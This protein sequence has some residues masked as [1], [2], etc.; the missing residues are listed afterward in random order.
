M[1]YKEKMNLV[2]SLLVNLVN[3][4]KINV[5]DRHIAIYLINNYKTVN[6]DTITILAKSLQVSIS[7]LSRFVKNIGFS[8]YGEFKDAISYHGDT[9]RHSDLQHGL[10]DIDD[11]QRLVTEEINYFYSN[12][13]SS[14]LSNL[15]D[16][17]YKTNDVALFGLLNSNNAAKELQYNLMRLNKICISYDNLMAQLNYLKNAKKDTL[18]IIFS[19]SGQYVLDNDY[20][21][22][23]KVISYLK[24]T[25][26]KTY[27]LTKNSE[28]INLDYLD[29]III[30]PTKNN[31]PN[32]TWQCICDLIFLMY[33][34]R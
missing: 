33:Q 4:P 10:V 23:Y 1:L 13:D 21:R 7:Q 27:L 3:N 6:M 22:Y 25:K 5:V 34:K 32:Y 24:N 15:I 2:I 29:E 18:V 17:L 20:S 9:K 28:T 31:L 19:L 11:Y 26:A 16:D 14:K 12:F 8:S 30:I